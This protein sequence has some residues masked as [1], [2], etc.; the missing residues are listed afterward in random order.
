MRYV[1]DF[2]GGKEDVNPYVIDDDVVMCCAGCLVEN[3]EPDKRDPISLPDGWHV[4]SVA[5]IDMIVSGNESASKVRKAMD[6]YARDKNIH[7]SNWHDLDR[8]FHE[9]V[10][11]LERRI[12]TLNGRFKALGIINPSY[13]SDPTPETLMSTGRCCP[14]CGG[15]LIYIRSVKQKQALL[16]MVAR[17]EHYRYA[18]ACLGSCRLV[19]IGR[20]TSDE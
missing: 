10:E 4:A 11:H 9:V 16:D 19:F 12:N 17:S 7:R 1:C 8:Y 14:D 20:R 15:P 5:A 13:N 2:C 6:N 3:T 18:Q